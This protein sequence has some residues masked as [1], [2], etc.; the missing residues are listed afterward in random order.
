MLAIEISSIF[1]KHK[2]GEELKFL[3]QKITQ[4]RQK[5]IEDSIDPKIIDF[6]KEI[7]GEIMT[8]NL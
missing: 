8:E 2:F 6:M 5:V 7:K 3:N 4:I 1:Q